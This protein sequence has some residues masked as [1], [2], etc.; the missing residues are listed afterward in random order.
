MRTFLFCAVLFGLLAT[1]VR[2]ETFDEWKDRKLGEVS[3][4]WRSDHYDLYVPFYAWHN[5][6]AY[7]DAH[8][9]KYNEKAFGFGFGKSLHDEKGD[10]Y[11]IYAFGFKDSNSKFETV[12]GYAYQKNWSLLCNSDFKVGVGYTLGMTQ[13]HEYLYIPVP[14]ILPIFGV[15]YKNLALQGGYVPGLH[16][17]GNVILFWMRYQFY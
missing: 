8:I 11:G 1:S 14:M 15:E 3:A 16:N 7:D 6:L 10:W 4:I 17:F 5:R 2:A 13:R 9:A 12:A